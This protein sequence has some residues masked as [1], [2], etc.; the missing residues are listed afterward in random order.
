MRSMR[1]WDIAP[2]MVLERELFGDE[3]WTDAMYWSELAERD[4]RLYLVEDA[5]GAI[6]AYGGLCAYAP[7]EAYIQTIGVTQSAQG[8]GLGTTLLLALVD[9]ARRRGVAHVDLEVKSDNDTARR[10]YERHGFVEIAVRRNYYQPSGTD[11]IVMRLELG[12]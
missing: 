4:T 11:A 7:H 9:E 12:G 8:R 1:W 6:T 2:V 10:L 5:Q 3:A